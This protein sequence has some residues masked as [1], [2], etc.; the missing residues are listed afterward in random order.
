M[1]RCSDGKRGG[2]CW[3][4]D[5]CMLSNSQIIY[6][7][8]INAEATAVLFFHQRCHVPLNHHEVYACG[9]GGEV[10]APT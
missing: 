5:M 4:K 9:C 8:F 3:R 10:F 2:S 7:L 6:V 1:V